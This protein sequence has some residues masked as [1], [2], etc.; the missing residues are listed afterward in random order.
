MKV[1]FYVAEVNIISNSEALC[2]AE[3]VTTTD[4]LQWD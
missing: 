2:S 4:S 1:K 3:K